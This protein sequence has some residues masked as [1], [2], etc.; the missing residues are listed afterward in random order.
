MLKIYTWLKQDFIQ[1]DF[2]SDAT[3]STFNIACASVHTGKKWPKLQLQR[4]VQLQKKNFGRYSKEL[5]NLK[6]SSTSKAGISA[7]VIMEPLAGWLFSF[8]LTWRWLLFCLFYYMIK[9]LTTS[10]STSDS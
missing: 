10:F 5:D 6:G 9:K 3:E 7:L 8:P 4:Y 1:V 2:L